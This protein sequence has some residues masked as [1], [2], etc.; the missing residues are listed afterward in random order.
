MNTLEIKMVE[1]LMDLSKNHGVVEVKAEFEAEAA[2]IEE[3]MRLKDIAGKAGLGLVLKIGGAEAITDMFEAQHIGVSGLVAPMIESGYAM[4]KYI[5]AIN[6]HFPK[7][8]RQKIQ[9]GINIETNLA[10]ANLA[11]ILSVPGIKVIDK[12]TVGRVDLTG[13]LGLTREEINCDQV[14][15]ITEEIFRE[16]KKRK[17]ITAMG[18][19]IAVE[20][21]PFIK[22][23]T[24]QKFLDY[25]ETRKIVFKTPKKFNKMGEA[26]VKANK[27][28][29]LWLENKKNHYAKI[30]RE[31]NKRIRML[32][33]RVK[34]M[35]CGKKEYS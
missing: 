33:K 24:S 7:D 31:D 32:K 25:F 29:L 13:S 18:G 26:I 28:E 11:D 1:L 20:A 23:L 27:F 34:L 21:V 14:Y 4:S 16:A 30:F 9:F 2:R 10:Y 22:K 17:K 6:N 3:V 35:P 8:A 15:Q 12:I 19:G 5:A